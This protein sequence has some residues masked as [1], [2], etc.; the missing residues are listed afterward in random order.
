[1]EVQLQPHDHI[2]EISSVKTHNIFGDPCRSATAVRQEAKSHSEN[3]VK[4]G[5]TGT[6]ITVDSMHKYVFNVLTPLHS[7]QPSALLRQQ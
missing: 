5:D 3:R 6:G 2:W 1:M 4:I 7:V